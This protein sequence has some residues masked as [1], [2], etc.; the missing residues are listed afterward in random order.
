MDLS[1]RE[2]ATQS[3]SAGATMLRDRPGLAVLLYAV[4]LVLALIIAVPLYTTFVEH[5]GITGFGPDMIRS[6]DLM[7][8]REAMDLASDG[9]KMMAIQLLWALPLYLLWKTAANM[10]IIYALHQ[11]AIW[12]FWRGVGYYTGKGLFLAL[13]FLLIKAV[14]VAIAILIAVA[15]GSVWTGEV[16]VFWSFVVVMPFLIISVVAVTDLFQRYA[17]IA[18]VVR[19]DSVGRAISAGFSWPIKYGAASYVYLAWFAI[20]TLILLITMTLNG[21]LHVGVEAI[22]LGFLVQQVSM[23]TRAAANVGW[24][25]SEVSLFERTHVNELPLIADAFPV[26]M[27]AGPLGIN[28]PP[29]DGQAQA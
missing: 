2:L 29:E 24:I 28:T 20:A 3:M 25:G 14:A 5:V 16:G 7:L 10:G 26:E 8:W 1:K 17:R 9:F 19:H 22:A 6:F 13:V 11:G 27:P 15:L 4:N 21:M 12:P 23:F 18:I